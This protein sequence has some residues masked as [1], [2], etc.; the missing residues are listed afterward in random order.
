[1]KKKISKESKKAGKSKA[2]K[3]VLKSAATGRF[4]SRKYAKKHPRTTYWERLANGK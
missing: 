4:V 2:K 3:R 1:M